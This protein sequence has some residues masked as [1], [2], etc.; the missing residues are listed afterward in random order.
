MYRLIR[1]KAT[2]IIG[3]MS[4]LGRKT[5]ELDLS[6]YRDKNMFVI[7]G[8]NASGKS[9]FLSLIHPTVG[10]ADGRNKFVIPKKEGSI[11]RTFEGD[12]GSTII[13][14]CIYMPVKTG[15]K[16]THTAK[17]YLAVKRAGEKEF[18]EM[19]SNGNV[20]SY[21][22]LLMTYFGITKDYVNFASYNDAVAGIVSMTDGERKSNV[23]SL[24][25][26]TGRYEIAFNT[27][28]EKYKE[29][30][31]LARNVAQK[32]MSSKDMDT[33]DDD[34]RRVSK[35]LK[36]AQ[37]SHDKVTKKLSEAE[38]RVSEISHGQDIDDMLAEYQKLLNGIADYE[39]RTVA[40]K[41]NILALADKLNL[42][43]E[44]S[45]ILTSISASK[46]SKEILKYER[47]VA[48][49][50]STLQTSGSRVD[51]LST[52]LSQTE[53]DIVEAESVLYGLQTQD[54]A[55]LEQTKAGYDERIKK[56]RY[57]KD[58]DRYEGLSYT[59]C[60][61]FSRN[62]MLMIQMVQALYDEYGD[63]VSQ[64]F[65]DL[66][67]ER[68]A[69]IQTDLA[70]LSATIETKTARKDM[71]YRQIIEKKQYQKF[72]DILDQRPKTCHDDSCPF[73]AN[74]VRWAHI[75]GEVVELE[76]QYRALDVEITSDKIAADTCNKALV[77]RRDAEKLTSFVLAN[78]DLMHRYL[79]LSVADLYASIVTGQWE[80]ALNILALKDIAAVLS[81]KDLYIKLTT[82]LIPEVDRSIEIAK[83]Y[84]TN[85]E[86]IISQLD[87]LTHTRDILKDE[88]DEITMNQTAS[89][90]MVDTYRHRLK[91][92]RALGDA[93]D[94]YKALAT[95]LLKSN[96][97]ASVREK[98]I[99]K[100]LELVDVCRGLQSE[101]E[102]ADR[103][104]A[105]LGPI[106]QQIM[107]EIDNL[108]RLQAEKD[109][110]DQEYLVVDILHNILQPGK[111]IR[112]E[113]LNIYF[114]DIYQIAN[115]LL[116]NTFGG[117]L[118][119]REFIITD[120]EF[121]I[122]FEYAG[123]VGSDVSR[124][125]SSQRATIA[126][127][128]S[129]AIISKL[130]D[131]YA[132]VSFDESDQT[133]SPANK[134]VFVDILSKYMKMVGIQQSFIIS[135]SP[136]YYESVPNLCFIGFPGYEHSINTR[137]NDIIDV[138]VA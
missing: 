105:E 86:M 11:I 39:S 127:A 42:N 62:V 114:F 41:N 130:V 53:K 8:D 85:R 61:S 40:A 137:V 66:S 116:L 14:K 58:M 74:A 100:I 29:L 119:L 115:Q 106:K 7:V 125:S 132:I 55:D 2:N 65:A 50:E 110:I 71:L 34:F 75:A 33:L 78:E 93:V 4:G 124:A 19:N 38:G 82:Q 51:K 67:A 3:F 21:T 54:I 107:I 16:D 90:R 9:T 134:A 99:N 70:T 26:N 10:P 109:R 79:G 133:L 28:N 118:R 52:E 94:E 81:E 22:T 108:T 1:F 25:P 23:S 64:Y 89:G 83:A 111:H 122:P 36:R 121:T 48:S 6:E 35:E 56:M 46:I 80:T 91:Q 117:K 104:V 57:T 32:I 120:K 101:L 126:I 113:L 43:T 76:E 128:I 49:A 59:E 60:I 44:Q 88:L 77:L 97:T 84:G 138:S 87:R 135:H 47:K 37:E 63:L 73:V 18:T 17:C 103:A 123:E 129:L 27:V 20:G 13:T 30:R 69:S 92:W 96:E 131:K 45:D 68:T 136:E 98:E 102:E 5:F 31:N 72:Q 15:G 24:I 112:K 12:D 95:A